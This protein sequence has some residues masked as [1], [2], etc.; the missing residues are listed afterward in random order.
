MDVNGVS[1]RNGISMWT[2]CRDKLVQ[3]C[4]PYFAI[5]GRRNYTTIRGGVFKGAGLLI[6]KTRP[7]FFLA[8]RFNLVCGEQCVATAAAGERERD[9]QQQL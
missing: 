6:N 8:F 7:A 4:L 2:V 1:E 5:Y 3:S 9:E